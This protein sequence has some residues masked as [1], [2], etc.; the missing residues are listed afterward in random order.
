MIIRFISSG[1][2]FQWYMTGLYAILNPILP[3]MHTQILFKNLKIILI[4]LELFWKGDGLFYKNN[5]I[6][7]L[8]CGQDGKVSKCCV[9][10]LLLPHQ[11]YN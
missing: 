9:H 3:C 6:K 8:D 2:L 10:L 4:K 7:N 1:G 5:K 11:N